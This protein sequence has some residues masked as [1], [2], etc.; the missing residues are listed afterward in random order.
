MRSQRFAKQ[1]KASVSS[2]RSCP[3]SRTEICWFDEDSSVACLASSLSCCVAGD[4]GGAIKFGLVFSRFDWIDFVEGD[5]V[6]LCG[7]FSVEEVDCL[8]G[9]LLVEDEMV[10][11][12]TIALNDGVIRDLKLLIICC[13]LHAE[14]VVPIDQ[15]DGVIIKEASMS[16]IL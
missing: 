3:R 6:G 2:L 14:F 15:S 11:D 5:E 10:V 9:V 13:C 8:L 16:T 12:R 7:V 4:E 1:T